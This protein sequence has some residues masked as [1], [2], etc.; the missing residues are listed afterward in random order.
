M[1]GS[2][3]SGIASLFG[4]AQQNQANSAQAAANRAFQADM[5]SNAHLREMRDLRQ[6]GLNPILSANK[7]ASTPGGSMAQMED[8]IGKG[9]SSAMEAKRLKNEIDMN[10]QQI[11]K[12]KMET[13]LIKA[14]IPGAAGRSMV[15]QG[16]GQTVQTLT[17]YIKN[18]KKLTDM[19]KNSANPWQL[20]PTMPKWGAD[21]H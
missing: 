9:V 12:A 2:I 20:L 21:K 7:G 18:I 13:N 5:S 10:K 19:F 6:S 17:P 4:G 15:D 16:L 14:Q 11:E 3:F 1:F 8:I